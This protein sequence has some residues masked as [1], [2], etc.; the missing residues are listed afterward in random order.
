MSKLHLLHG[1]A[2]QGAL[3]AETVDEMFRY[4]LNK[5]A[6]GALLGL[7]VLC[8]L[9]AFGTWIF[10]RLNASLWA[11]LFVLLMLAGLS[12]CSMASYWVNF[13]RDSFVAVSA[14]FLFVGRSERAWKIDWSLLDKRA[15]GLHAMELSPLKGGL[16]IEVAGQRIKLHLFNAFAYLVDIQTFMLHVL[17]RLKPHEAALVDARDPE[18]DDDDDD[19]DHDGD[20]SG[21]IEVENSAQEV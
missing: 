10:T 14:N 16:V 5:Y 13:V 9:G 8:L 18:D 12:F 4:E 6:A 17:Q 15:L 2:V 3:E 21:E 19:D 7:G 11:T 1:P 20:D